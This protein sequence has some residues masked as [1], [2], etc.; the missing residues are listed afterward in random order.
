MI[1]LID[2]HTFLWYVQDHSK[3]S[4]RVKDIFDADDAI[5]MISIASI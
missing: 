3:C 5:L 1:V 2:T 4:K